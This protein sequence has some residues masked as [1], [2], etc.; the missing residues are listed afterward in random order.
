MACSDVINQ[1]LISQ[2]QQWVQDMHERYKKQIKIVTEKETVFDR[3]KM[4]AMYRQEKRRF[5]ERIEAMD[6]NGGKGLLNQNQ[7]TRGAIMMN[8]MVN[9]F[10]FE[11]FLK[12]GGKVKHL[13]NPKIFE[14]VYKTIHNQAS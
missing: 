3:I 5:L 13:V 1:V 6:Q 10:D 11:K 2:H 12:E 9:I 8:K 4:D 14:D 7:K